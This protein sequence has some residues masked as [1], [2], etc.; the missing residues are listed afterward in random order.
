[1][2]VR[3]ELLFLVGPERVELSTRLYKSPVLPLNYG[4]EFK[5]LSEKDIMILSALILG[6]KDIIKFLAFCQIFRASY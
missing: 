1:M 2:C 4:P 3:L 5:I 6:D